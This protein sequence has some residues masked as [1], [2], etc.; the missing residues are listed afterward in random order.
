MEKYFCTQ[1][2]RKLVEESIVASTCKSAITLESE[3]NSGVFTLEWS[4]RSAPVTDDDMD[5]FDV[6]DL[7]HRPTA[8]NTTLEHASDI[9]YYTASYIERCRLGVN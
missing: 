2:R 1:K 5:M 8:I 4:K 3:L 7:V 6:E 9:L